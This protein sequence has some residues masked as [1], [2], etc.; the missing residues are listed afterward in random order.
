[1]AMFSGKTALVT[2]SGAGI[3]R[4]TALKFAAEGANVVVS[5]IH[6]PAG[7]ETIAGADGRS[8]SRSIRLRGRVD[9]IFIEH[10]DKVLDVLPDVLRA[11]D[12][13][14]TQGAGD[15]GALSADIAAAK[16]GFK[17]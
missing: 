7:E 6:V 12:I 4:A 8:L 5:D 14:L 9:P 15:V 11:G 16:L 17:S 3:G 1:M 2:G 10:K 13:L